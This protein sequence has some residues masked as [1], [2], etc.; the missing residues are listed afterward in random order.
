MLKKKALMFLLHIDTSRRHSANKYNR[1]A[2]KTTQ[3]QTGTKR[4]S[5]VYKFKTVVYC[6]I[7]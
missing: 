7:I 6:G 3:V 4:T 2:I 5:E 1:N